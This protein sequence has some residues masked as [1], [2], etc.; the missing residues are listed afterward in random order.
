[1]DAMHV[2]A[3]N[4]QLLVFQ[5]GKP[6]ID[7][8]LQ[9]HVEQSRKAGHLFDCLCVLLCLC[10]CLACSSNAAMAIAQ[11]HSRA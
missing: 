2:L 7:E 11:S 6:V 1:M 10:V 5:N 9:L 8:E 4:E 3:V